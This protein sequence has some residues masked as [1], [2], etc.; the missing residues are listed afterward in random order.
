MGCAYCRVNKG[1][2]LIRKTF[3]DMSVTKYDYRSLEKMFLEKINSHS[4]IREQIFTYIKPYLYNA[5][6]SNNSNFFCH[7]KL[8]EQ[9]YTQFPCEN[10]YH[11]ILFLYS[12]LDPTKPNSK[13]LE[14]FTEILSRIPLKS[15][16]DIKKIIEDYLMINL[17][18]PTLIV[19]KH[20]DDLSKRERYGIEFFVNDVYTQKNIFKYMY[21]IFKNTWL[22]YA[23]TSSIPIS[24]VTLKDI[25]IGN[26]FLFNFAEMRDNFYNFYEYDLN[27]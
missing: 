23:D 10:I 19:S 15:N 2:E 20:I 27:K 12:F 7:E 13:K 26:E 14:E 18:L 11:A 17:Y 24:E 16:E 22:N 9:I 6:P 1:Q 4:N 25:F 3:M 8:I 5:H 21:H